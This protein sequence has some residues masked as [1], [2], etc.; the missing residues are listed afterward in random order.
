MLVLLLI[1]VLSLAGCNNRYMGYIIEDEPS[2][3]NQE[4]ESYNDEKLKLSK[5][6]AIAQKPQ[7]NGK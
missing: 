4:I 2:T 6:T 1:L 7:C 5:T 3:Q